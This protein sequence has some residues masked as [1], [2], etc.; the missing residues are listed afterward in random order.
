M[1]T[2]YDHCPLCGSKDFS[3]V[4]LIKDYSVS[5]ES[6]P[7]LHC[8]ECELNFTQNI[9]DA[10]NIGR[11]YQSEDYISH[12][13]TRKGFI[14]SMYHR[15]RNYTLVSKRKMVIKYARTEKGSLLD[16]GSGTGAFL[17]EM[18][19]Y[20]WDVTGLEPDPGA[21]EKAKELYGLELNSAEHLSELPDANFDVVTLWH[22]L[23]HVH[24]LHETLFHFIPKTPGSHVCKL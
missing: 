4:D 24:S 11:Y 10:T 6:F 1:I 9:P 20:G 23:E 17:N 12:T 22:V 5:K 8:R 14:N 7:V 13:D 18:K 15:V 3:E 19:T 16:Y 2:R 21:V